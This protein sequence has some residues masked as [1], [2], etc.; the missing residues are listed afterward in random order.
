MSLKTR[1]PLFSRDGNP[2]GDDQPRRAGWPAEKD[3]GLPAL[4]PACQN[5]VRRGGASAK[6]GRPLL[7]I[8]LKRFRINKDSFFSLMTIVPLNF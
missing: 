3:L 4:N 1:K 8:D 6:A 5:L 2:F 7:W